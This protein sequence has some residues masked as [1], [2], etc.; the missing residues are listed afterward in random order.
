MRLSLILLSSLLTFGSSSFASGWYPSA[1]ITQSAAIDLQPLRCPTVGKDYS[2]MISSLE[3][4]QD[5]IKKD[6]NCGKL[7]ENL[8]KIGQL[9]GERR[10]QFLEAI[11]KINKGETLPDKQMDGQILKYAQ[12]VTVAAGSLATLIAQGDQCLG[13]SDISTSLFT[14][15]SFVNEASTMLSTVAG[16]WGPALSIGGKVVAG[17]LT[18]VD[19]FIKSLPGYDFKDKKDWQ[20]YVETLCSFHEQQDEIY[21]L[22][23]PEKAIQDLNQLNMKIQEQL[24]HAL[25]QT[26]DGERITSTFQEEN[27]DALAKLTQDPV[28]LQAVRLLSAQKWVTQR[29]QDIQ[30]EAKDPLAPGQYIVQKQRDEI[31]NFLIGKQAPKFITFQVNEANGALYDLDAFIRTEVL[32]IYYQIQ[33]AEPGLLPQ[34]QNPSFVWVDPQEAV[35][36]LLKL[37]EN[38][39]LGKGV[40]EEKIYTDMIYFK[41]E[42]NKL[43][44]AV[45][46]SYG[47][48]QS[49]CSFFQKAAYYN[50]QIQASC[51][52]RRASQVE[53]QMNN[54]TATGLALEVPQYLRQ[55]S[56]SQGTNWTES[57]Q[58][59]VN[60]L[61]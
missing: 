22:L 18:G 51:N 49:F 27:N 38:Q 23:H 50:P 2:Q 37:D 59:W 46:V 53:A 12:D 47:V 14:L 26:P 56:S 57:L 35:G 6:A 24:V 19:Q 39:F 34:P 21:A 55:V 44:D 29:I 36:T 60:E 43:W 40:K 61:N 31:E 7:T 25:G 45:N 11:A 33:N 3:S 54:L 13:E 16:P 17:F 58:T 42:L 20:G 15:S 32:P 4:L 30:V 48:K 9:S 28:S 5:K 8:Q 41:R 10:T 52:S 1:T